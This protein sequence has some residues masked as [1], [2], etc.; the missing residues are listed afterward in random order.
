[1]RRMPHWLR[2]VLME[3]QFKLFV[4]VLCMISGI[5]LT[6]NAVS[7][8]GSLLVVLAPMGIRLW[9]I[10]IGLG[11]FLVVFGILLRHVKARRR[12]IEGLMIEAAGLIPLGLAALVVA[13]LAIY[14][15]GTQALFGA[16]VYL[17]FTFACAAR[18]WATQQIVKSV[19]D[20][21]EQEEDVRRE[22]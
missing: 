19:R 16:S 6:I 4:A 9:G 18:F 3:D 10:S 21:I 15:I 12:Y 17:M 11:G 5:P 20:A 13:V 14:V 8:P 2:G 1:M 7:A 22:H